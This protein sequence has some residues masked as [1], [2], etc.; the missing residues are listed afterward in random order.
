LIDGAG[1]FKLSK[2][3]I[4]NLEIVMKT[5]D[6]HCLYQVKQKFGGSVKLR[7]GVN[8]LRYRLHHKK[9][10]LNLISCV[11]GEIRNPVRLIELNKLCENYNIQLIQPS[12]LTY[13]NG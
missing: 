8:F 9:G 4:A 5:K 11:N 7:S 3:G 1:Y 13:Y 2:K 12:N 6:K 10:L